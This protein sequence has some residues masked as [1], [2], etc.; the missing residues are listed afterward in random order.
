[1]K[2]VFWIVIAIIIFLGYQPL[3]EAAAYRFKQPKLV[4]EG[5]TFWLLA[6]IALVGASWW[7]LI[8][9]GL[10]AVWLKIR[11]KT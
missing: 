8:V 11:R 4:L 9:A 6:T 7:P 2:I 10:L 3:R 5:L 1:M